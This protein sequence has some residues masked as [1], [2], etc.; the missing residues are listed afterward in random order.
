M[1]TWLDDE[2]RAREERIIWGTL[3]AVA[4]P[5]DIQDI[6]IEFGEDHSGDPAVWIKLFV[7]GTLRPPS[8]QW[9][10]VFE[11]SRRISQ[12]LI[13]KRLRHWPYVRFQSIAPTIA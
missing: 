11:F 2:V 12:M 8:P 10:T 6:Q 7:T 3:A 9:E 5:P 4:R 1:D 13:E